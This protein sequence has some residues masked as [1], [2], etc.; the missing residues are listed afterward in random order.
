MNV[1][2]KCNENLKEIVPVTAYSRSETTG[3]CGI[4]KLFGHHDN[5]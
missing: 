4:F 3:K 5:K 2:K 1:G